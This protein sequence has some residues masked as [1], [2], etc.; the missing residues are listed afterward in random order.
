MTDGG[1]ASCPASGLYT[2]IGGHAGIYGAVG[3][4]VGQEL[5]NADIASYFFYQGEVCSGGT[6]V[7]GGSAAQA[8]KAH[9]EGHPTAA[10][11]QECF[12]D[13]VGKAAGGTES[14]PTTVDAGTAGG[15]A[16][17]CRDITIA[18]K[19]LKIDP[20]VFTEFLTIAAGVLMPALN[21]VDKACATQDLTTLAGALTSFETSVVTVANDAAVGPFTG[22]VDAALNLG[23]DAN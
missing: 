16:F 2:R 21:T 5:Q 1:A 22:S 11:I 12:T 9:A 4:V 18:H 14:Y 8:A 7:D 6:C 19:A 10:Q 13:L 3:L 23:G 17:T 15:G 20:A